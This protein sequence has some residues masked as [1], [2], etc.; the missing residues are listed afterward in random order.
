M[1]ASVFV[2]GLLPEGQHR[3]ALA[4]ALKVAVNDVYSL[5]SRSGEMS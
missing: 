5:L 4:S 1:N 3:Q 2:A